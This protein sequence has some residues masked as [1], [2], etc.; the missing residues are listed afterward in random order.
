MNYNDFVIARLRCQEINRQVKLAERHQQAYYRDELIQP[1]KKGP[2]AW[3]GVWK[4][5]C[6]LAAIVR[7]SVAPQSSV[8]LGR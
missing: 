7:G 5:A 6:T 1:L 3:S 8:A 4:L 2:S